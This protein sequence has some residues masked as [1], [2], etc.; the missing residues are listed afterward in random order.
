[1]IFRTDRIGDFIASKIII[2]SIKNQNKN[3][4]IDIVCSRYNKNYIS[5]YKSIN[6]LF[7]LEKRNFIKYLKNI[8]LLKNLNYDY[9]IL[10][11]GKR[12]SLLFS[13]F[14]KSNFKILLFKD[15]VFIF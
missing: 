10:L 3:N 6:N 13:F 1:M 7:V 5:H 11:D 12:R 14:K 2:E 9:L 8:K 15:K 4:K